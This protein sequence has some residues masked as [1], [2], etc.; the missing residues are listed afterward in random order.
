MAAHP[1]AQCTPRVGS[2]CGDPLEFC[3]PLCC[4]AA[5]PFG[6]FPL[7]SCPLP[8]S[9]GLVQVTVAPYLSQGTSRGGP[10]SMDRVSMPPPNP[11]QSSA[12]V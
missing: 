8:D 9:A 3:T 10:N 2:G 1:E 6:S 5:L 4:R 11:S 12:S 7:S